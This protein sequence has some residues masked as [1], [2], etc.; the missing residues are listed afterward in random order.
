MSR[1]SNNQLKDEEIN[2]SIK[3]T[4]SMK[5]L[6][7]IIEQEQMCDSDILTRKVQSSSVISK[8][9]SLEYDNNDNYSQLT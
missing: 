2:L 9:L 7:D 4:W 5:E 8:Y 3:R 1:F 6:S